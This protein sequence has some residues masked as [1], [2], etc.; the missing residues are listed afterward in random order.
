MA[1]QL[2]GLRGFYRWLLM[3]KRIG[4]DPTVNVEIAGELEGAAEVAGGE[5][6]GG[7]LERVG[8]RRGRRM[9]RML[10]RCGIMRFW[11]CCMRAGCGW[12]RS[13]RCGWRICR[14]W[15]CSGCRCGV[16][17]IRNGLCRWGGR[18]ARRWRL[19][20]AGAAGAGEA[21]RAGLQR[22]MF[23]SVR[24]RVLTRQWVWEMVRDA[25]GSSRT[26]ERRAARISCGIAVRPT[27]WSMGRICVQCADSFLGHADIA[28]TQVYTH[29][30]LGRLKAVHRMHHPRGKALVDSSIGTSA[31]ER[32]R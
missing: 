27:W 2:S 15:T 31:H 17:A 20:G 10:C 13:A 5:R 19:S 11:S 12:G 32:V 6:S 24:G 26:A 25:S 30:A 18:P 1:R 3:D 7:M 14:I 8:E 21:F 4:H 22:A 23:L 16:R 28:T 9:L 29:V